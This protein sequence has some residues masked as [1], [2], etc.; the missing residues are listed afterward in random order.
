MGRGTAV[1]LSPLG[2]FVVWGVGPGGWSGRSVVQVAGGFLLLVL[3][4]FCAC[5]ALWG[6]G[7]WGWWLVG[8]GGGG[9]GVWGVSLFGVLAIGC[10][11]CVF[12]VS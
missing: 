10:L 2:G 7:W 9:G 3:M 1:L 4:A 8:V 5:P 6:L 12:S 11:F